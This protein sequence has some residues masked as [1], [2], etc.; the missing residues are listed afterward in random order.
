[1]EI[2]FYIPE[3]VLWIGATVCVLAAL[4]LLAHF[5]LPGND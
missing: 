2:S 3:P 5:C 4:K 1:M